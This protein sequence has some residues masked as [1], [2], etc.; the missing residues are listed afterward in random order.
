MVLSR[1]KSPPAAQKGVLDSLTLAS[2][3]TIS[4]RIFVA[5]HFFTTLVRSVPFLERWLDTESLGVLDVV[6][7]GI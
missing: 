1:P 5:L 4:I 2:A 6:E 7:G 3:R